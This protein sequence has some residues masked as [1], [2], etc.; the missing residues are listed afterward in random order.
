MRSDLKIIIDA[1][2]QR[3][4]QTDEQANNNA[5]RVDDDPGID[6]IARRHVGYQCRKST[7]QRKRK[8]HQNK[9]QQQVLFNQLTQPTAQSHGKQHDGDDHRPLKHRISQK[10]RSQGRQHILRHNTRQPRRKQGYL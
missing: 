2:H 10:V 8:L 7:K 1:H 3:N 9:G 6:R 5:Q 4:F